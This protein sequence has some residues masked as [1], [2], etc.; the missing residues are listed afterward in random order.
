MKTIFLISVTLWL[1][2]GQLLGQAEPPFVPSGFVVPKEYVAPDLVILPLTK[3][4][5]R[6]DYDA[7]MVSKKELRNQFGGEW[8]ADDFSLAQNIEDIKQH[9]RLAQ[10]R[11]SFTYSILDANA[12]K[13]L[14]CIYINPVD[15]AGYDA[16]VHIWVR[17]DEKDREAFLRQG[18]QDWLLERWPFR[19]VFFR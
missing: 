8:P 19:S 4:L 18:M 7:V 5:A 2:T 17:A 14:G 9:E 10:E 3:D 1:S 15:S 12:E 16:Q 13:V 11:V 6:L